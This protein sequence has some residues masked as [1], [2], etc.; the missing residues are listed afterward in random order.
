M[1]GYIY[2]TTNLITNKIYIGQKKS[3]KFL[4]EKYLGSGKVLKQALIKYGK[5]NFKVELL[6][7]IDCIEKMDEREI[8]WIAYFN[9]TNGEIG[10]NRSE[11]GNVNRTLVEENNPFY[12]KH[13]SEESRKKMSEN[14]ALYM[15]G[16]HH[17]EETKAKIS[18][19]NLGKVVSEETKHKLSEN[20]KTNLNYGM[21]GKHL[22]NEVKE[23]LSKSR[24][25]KP[26]ASKGRVHITND[27][28]DKMIDKSQIDLFLANGWRLGRKKFSKSACD[29][30]S[31]GH[32]NLPVWNKGKKWVTNGYE[33]KLIDLSE[34]DDHLNKGWVKGRTL[35]R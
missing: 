12:H 8:Y 19:G 25:G 4:G 14:N 20:A 22:S 10:Y 33:S 21:R 15:L 17:S 9:A 2:K 34:L 6:E 27:I 1:Y 32:K 23:K 28:V 24:K 5:E 16:K 30:I 13:H 31:R 18:K 3:N 26:S 11:G 35:I 29:N 7:E